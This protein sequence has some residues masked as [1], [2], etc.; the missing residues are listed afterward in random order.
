MRLVRF[1]RSYPG[2]AIVVLLPSILAA[3]YYTFIAA[4]IYES[5][6]QYVVKNTSVQSATTGI[7]SFLQSAGLGNA[8]SDSYTV[9]AY[10]LSRDAL[11]S[12]EQSADIRAIY[13]RPEAKIDFIAKFP[14][15]LYGPSFENLFIHYGYWAE[16]DYDTQAGVSTLSVYAFRPD[17]AQLVARKLLDLSE[18]LVNELN[19]RAYNDALKVAKGE[20]ERL[21]QQSADIQKQITDFRFRELML[22]PN[23]S[24]T[25]AL[26]R[27]AS[28]DADLVATRS[29]LSQIQQ[30]SPQS[31][32]I[33]SLRARI[34]SLQQQVAAEEQRDSGGNHSLAPKMAEYEQLL[35]KQQF[36]QVVLQT[37]VSA[38]ESAE[39]TA[40]QQQLYIERV[41]VPNAP[42]RAL[43][44]YRL[45]DFILV[46]ITCLLLYGIG[47]M[48]IG[49]IREH[50]AP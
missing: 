23:A 4:D 31:P 25:A 46:V 16:V 37:A 19:E 47:R 32:Q 36:V 15:M 41:S 45:L 17:D 30:S 43:Y 33:P 9:S 39:V 29:L 13:N 10:L 26:S 11:K 40:Q 35:M 44:P 3:L 6:A 7:A 38:L 21:Q 1:L 49:A 18:A 5:D 28:M 2:F 48:M 42:D 24:S 22:D 50:V 12:L 27:L 14:N 8:S 20:V 34:D